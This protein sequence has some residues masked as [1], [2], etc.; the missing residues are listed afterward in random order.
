M[1]VVKLAN[2]LPFWGL[3]VPCPC[4]CAGA[5]AAHDD[6]M[7]M[8]SGANR[9]LYTPDAAA[10]V[11]AMERGTHHDCIRALRG[12]RSVDVVFEGEWLAVIDKPAGVYCNALLT[13]FPCPAVSGED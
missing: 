9:L 3:P 4:A 6:V 13:S 12:Y 7:S 11:A 5:A 10:M 1:L 8:P 2:E